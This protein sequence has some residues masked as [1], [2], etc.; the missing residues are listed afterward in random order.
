MLTQWGDA[1]ARRN[2]SVCPHPKAFL[3]TSFCLYPQSVETEFA[4][5]SREE[6]RAEGCVCV[7]YVGRYERVR[8]N[9]ISFLLVA[10][11]LVKGGSKA[12]P[13]LCSS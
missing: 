6:S 4:L 10:K 7:A 8:F 3:K 13:Y 11:C 2:A 9:Q 5:L 1:T 12:R